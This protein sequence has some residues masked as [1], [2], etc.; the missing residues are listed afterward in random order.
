MYMQ[1]SLM[2]CEGVNSYT[3]LHKIFYKTNAQ[4]IDHLHILQIVHVLQISTKIYN[5]FERYK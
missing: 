5:Y 1:D 2:I 4:S 3:I